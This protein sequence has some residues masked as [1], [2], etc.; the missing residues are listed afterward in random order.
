MNTKRHIILAKNRQDAEALRDSWLSE[1]HA[2]KVLRIHRPKREPT[3]LLNLIGGQ[4]VPRVSI[5]I[6]YEQP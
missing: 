6:D 3:I 2:I 5:T 1:N 4:H